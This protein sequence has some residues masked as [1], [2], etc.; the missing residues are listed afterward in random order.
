MTNTKPGIMGSTL[1]RGLVIATIVV[2]GLA[3]PIDRVV[4]GIPAWQ[5]LGADAWGAYSRH[6]DLG[7]GLIVYPVTGIGLAVLAIAAAISSRVDRVTPRAARLPIYLAALG[8]IGVMVTTAVAAPVML[9][10]P[11]LDDRDAVADAFER[12]T[13]WGLQI[14][15]AFW[16]VVL[17][18]SVWALAV[19]SRDPRARLGAPSPTGQNDSRRSR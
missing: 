7:A 15:G 10:L 4:V 6:A 2:S 13:L 16:A 14:R 12:F 1:T 9:S 11:N 19:F 5:N 3:S 17:L 8:A 18:A